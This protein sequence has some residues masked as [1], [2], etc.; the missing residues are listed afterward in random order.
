MLLYSRQ[1]TILQER[2]QT[3]S[4]WVFLSVFSH[5]RA[6]RSYWISFSI[7]ISHRS[8]Q[9]LNSNKRLVHGGSMG[10]SEC[11]LEDVDMKLVLPLM[12]S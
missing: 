7:Y 1:R 9:T 10:S 2:V 5:R 12:N 11:L 8:F 3:H 4:H 6:L